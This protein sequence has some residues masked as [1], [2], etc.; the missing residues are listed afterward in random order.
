MLKISRL[1]DRIEP[2]VHFLIWSSF[3]MV[4]WLQVRTLGP[5]RKV[6]GSIYPPLI[7]NTLL[8]MLLFY[9]NA[10]YLIPRFFSRQRFA[11]YIASLT[12][13]YVGIVLIN[14]T[15]DHFYAIS[16]FS[17]EKE[18]LFAEVN[19][20][21]I[22]KFL[23]LSL[24]LGYGLTKNWVISNKLQQQLV[25]ENLNTQLK[26]L[27]AQ[28]NPHFL[29]N[30]LNMA[31]AS[32]VKSNDEPTA[33]IIEKISGFMRYVLYESNEDQVLLEKELLYI[34]NYINLQLQRL[35][36]EIAGKVKY[37][38]KGD[39]Q[40]FTIAPMILIPFIENVFKHGIMLSKKPEMSISLSIH[41]GVL[42]FESKNL[43]NH[44]PVGPGKAHSGIGMK[45]V[46]ERLL[47]MYPNQYS[48]EIN[49]GDDFF[50][51]TLQIQL[52]PVHV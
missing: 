28:I 46:K 15:F 36:P 52:K 14:T 45:N 31:Y 40:S 38:V 3:F 16:L 42:L 29:F 48:L 27:K 37:E 34:D 21:L 44:S 9:C 41:S 50:Q 22:S 8:S 18:P 13:I 6:D 26:Y 2:L 43:K 5:F 33:D 32:A 4:M 39:Y 7:W 49:D 35:S 12:G 1:K 51:V 24:S 20:N 10:L 11:W 23:I 17:S 25:S 47:L 19:A 30:T